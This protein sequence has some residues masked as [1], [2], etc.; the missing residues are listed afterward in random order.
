MKNKK[1][2]EEPK[3]LTRCLKEKDGY[4]KNKLSVSEYRFTINSI[5]TEGMPGMKDRRWQRRNYGKILK[6]NR[7]KRT[8]RVKRNTDDNDNH[9]RNSK[10]PIVVALLLHFKDKEDVLYESK[11]Y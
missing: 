7:V 10:A 4:L 2:K 8:H 3:R 1:L 6:T 9:D 11:R 5:R